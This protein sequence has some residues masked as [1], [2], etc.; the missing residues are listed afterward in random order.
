[1]FPLILVVSWTATMS[2]LYSEEEEESAGCVAEAVATNST[3]TTPATSTC[4]DATTSCWEGYTEEPYLLILSIPMI[5][6]LA[7]GEYSVLHNICN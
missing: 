4:P 6:A 3:T 2:T 1:M 5:I 7:V